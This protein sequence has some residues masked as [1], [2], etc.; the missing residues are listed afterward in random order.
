MEAGYALRPGNQSVRKVTEILQSTDGDSEQTYIDFYIQKLSEMVKDKQRSSIVPQI[1]SV[2]T[3]FLR[4][5]LDRWEYYAP[6]FSLIQAA[7][8][9]S[10]SSTKQEANYA[11]NR[12]V[13]LSL[14][15]G[16][17]PPK[18]FNAL[19]QPFL[20][21]LRRKLSIKQPEESTKMRRTVISGACNLLYYAFRPGHDR[22]PLPEVIWDATVQPLV[23]QLVGL[24]GTREPQSD[25]VMQASRI[26][27]GLLD[28]AT[29]V[30]WREDRIMDLPP[31]RPDELP[32]IES[33][34]IRKNSERIF[35]AVGPIIEM[36][37]L[38]LANKESLA[39]R[40]WQ[41]LLG[42]VAAAS[43]KDIKVSEDTLKFLAS[44]FSLLSLVWSKGCQGDEAI[45]TQKFFPS[46]RNFVKVLFDALGMLPFTE[47]KL[48]MTVANV[49]VPVA[50]PSQRLNQPEKPQ[51][52]V[53]NPLQ[54][55][56]SIL[57]TMP[58]GAADD[59]HF[60]DFFQ[61]VFD[62]F[63][64]GKNAK[65]RLGVCRELSLLLPQNTLSPY[66]VWILEASAVRLALETPE[67][68]SAPRIGKLPGPEFR[69]VVSLLERGL[70]SHPNLPFSHWHAL[71]EYFSGR[72]AREF[73]DAGRAI[74]IV[75]PLA[76][77]MLSNISFDSAKL[78]TKSVKTTQSLFETA[79]LPR[80]R[81]ALDAAQR[82][83]WGSPYAATKAG[84][85]DPFDNLYRLGN[86]ILS[87]C[88]ENLRV[89]QTTDIASLLSVIATFLVALFPQTELNT[90]HKLQE[91]LSLWFQDEKAQ[92]QLSDESPLS[93]SVSARL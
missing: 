76:K 28:V 15:D 6:W 66:A 1:W 49:F 8:N 7:F 47:K 11:W 32:S 22:S 65:S 4:C 27:V 89:T 78:C 44:S 17:A 60:A 91:G 40:L 19:C 42:S 48:S 72:V 31:V 77:L 67:D 71:F 23:S 61:S 33:K 10:D 18:V 82:K 56:F 58:P 9:T 29:P 21:Q 57:C 34:W 24:D 51:G 93:K 92:L 2:V 45:L 75:E 59:E 37:F 35:K 90:V 43:A 86:L 73:G 46:V 88:Y 5:P 79:R 13:Y 84:S 39:Y 54:H 87:S 80:D 50:T 14:A 63:L 38:D 12:Y 53:R 3:L 16:K 55:L 25:D 41:A 64:I 68:L 70:V 85:S 62:I 52:V 30:V 74:V 83:I 69:E 20:S 26:L 36:K 81:Q